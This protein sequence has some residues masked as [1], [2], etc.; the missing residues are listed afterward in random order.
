MITSSNVLYV[1]RK[2]TD[3]VSGHIQN[4]TI[5]LAPTL[6]LVVTTRLALRLDLVPFN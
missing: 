4:V 5:R 3:K 2:Q 1:L 6:Y